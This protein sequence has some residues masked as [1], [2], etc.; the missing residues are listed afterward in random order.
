MVRTFFTMN[1]LFSVA[2]SLIALSLAFSCQKDEITQ[3][4]TEQE[5]FSSVTKSNDFDLYKDVTLS[6]NRTTAILRIHANTQEDL[7]A[8]TPDNFALVEVI[9]SERLE[10][11]LIRA[12][13][14]DPNPPHNP[15]EDGDLPFITEPDVRS[16]MGFE[17]LRIN[18]P[19]PNNH[20]AVSFFHP[21][22]GTKAGWQ[23]FTHYS[24]AGLNV[25]QHCDIARHSVWRRVYY[26]LKYMSSSTSNWS[27]LQNEWRKLSNNQTMSYTRTPCFQYR[28]RVKTKKSSAYTVSFY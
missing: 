2:I 11:A 1:R 26:G 24:I 22:E 28:A 13:I 8:Y 4:I 10:D 14:M 5:E 17:V 19:D 7:D 6:V 15:D 16:S 18:N 23:Y 12:R 3:T 27:V 9:G 25:N 21:A 20:Y